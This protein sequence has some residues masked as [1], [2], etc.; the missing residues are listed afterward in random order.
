MDVPER[1]LALRYVGR[2]KARRDNPI[3]I[4]IKLPSHEQGVPRRIDNGFAQPLS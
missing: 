4:G 3:A 2:G 1:R